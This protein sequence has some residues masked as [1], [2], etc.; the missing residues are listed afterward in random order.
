M[1]RTWQFDT[2]M[3]NQ[4]PT[5]TPSSPCCLSRETNCTMSNIVVLPSQSHS[6]ILLGWCIPNRQVHRCEILIELTK[7]RVTENSVL[8]QER[9]FLCPVIQ[10]VTAHTLSFG[11]KGIRHRRRFGFFPVEAANRGVAV[12]EDGFEEAPYAVFCW[13]CG[14]YE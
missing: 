4:S 12:A 9:G 13:C 8:H 1:Q 6:I 10:P 5:L 11:N 3:R 2:K 7:D 14:Q